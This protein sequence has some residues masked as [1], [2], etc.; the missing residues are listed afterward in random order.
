MWN[1][2]EVTLRHYYSGPDCRR[3]E[4]LQISSSSCRCGGAS[5]VASRLAALEQS[6][7]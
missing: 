3:G 2:F 6:Y 5:R 4:Q 7:A 1:Y